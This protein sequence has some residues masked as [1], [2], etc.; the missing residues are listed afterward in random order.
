MDYMCLNDKK[1]DNNPILVIHDTGREC[2]WAILG[3][4]IGDDGYIAQRA[5][6]IVRRLGYMKLVFKADQEYSL[7]EADGAIRENLQK[8]RE[9]Q[10][11]HERRSL[12]SNSGH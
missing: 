4:R 7:N 1:D 8:I 6:D 3:R 12:R 11:L 9:S 5:T 2:T 10:R